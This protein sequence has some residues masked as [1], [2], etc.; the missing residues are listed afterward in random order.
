MV[1]TESPLLLVIS[2]DSP[3]AGPEVYT[4][5]YPTHWFRFHVW[6]LSSSVVEVVPPLVVPTKKLPVAFS[7]IVTG[8]PPEV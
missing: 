5:V 4:R 2:S 3:M 1:V 8:C 7:S 6:P